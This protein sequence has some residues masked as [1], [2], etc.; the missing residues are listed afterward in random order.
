[1]LRWDGGRNY[2]E[3]ESVRRLLSIL[4]ILQ[5]EEKP[6]SKATLTLI[7]LVPQWRIKQ[8]HM[9]QLLDET[10]IYYAFHYA[11]HHFFLINE[12]TELFLLSF[13]TCSYCFLFTDETLSILSSK[14][15]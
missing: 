1:V 10:V 14:R 3:Q 8:T 5:H 11:K 6:L 13:P 15:L 4:N 12:L 7:A 2:I 9:Q